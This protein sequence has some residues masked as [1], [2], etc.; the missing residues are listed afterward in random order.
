MNLDQIKLLT[1]GMSCHSKNSCLQIF[2]VAC[3]IDKSYDLWR[4]FADS[5]PVQVSVVRLVHHAAGRVESEDVVTHRA[6]IKKT[7]LGVHSCPHMQDSDT[8]QASE[9]LSGCQHIRPR[10]VGTYLNSNIS[11]K[12]LTLL[13]FQMHAWRHLGRAKICCKL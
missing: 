2:F 1:R 9:D 12:W 5:N 7:G 11:A 4:L 13:F 10:L 8:T 3:Q 6:G